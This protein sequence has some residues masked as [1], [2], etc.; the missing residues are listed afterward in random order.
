MIFC[1]RI[2]ETNGKILRSTKSNHHKM[3]VFMKRLVLAVF[4]F[5]T[6]VGTAMLIS[7][8]T[9][10]SSQTAAAEAWGSRPGV[11]YTLVM[12]DDTYTVHAMTARDTFGRDSASIS[13]FAAAFPNRGDDLIIFN[14][15]FFVTATWDPVGALV[16]QGRVV[17]S[18]PNP[19]LNWG[20]GFTDYNRFGLFYGRLSGNQVLDNLTREP[21]PYVTVF[22][23]YPHLVVNGVRPVLAPF[24]G[25]DANELNRRITRGFV[26]QRADGSFMIGRANNTNL[27]ELQNIAVDFGL[28]NAANIDGGASVGIW[29][30]GSYIVRPGRQLPAVIVITN[31][32][33]EGLH[34][35]PEDLEPAATHMIF[36]AD[37]TNAVFE[38]EF[39]NGVNYATTEVLAEL[40]FAFDFSD[41]VWG[42]SL[43]VNISRGG[44][45]LVVTMGS[46][47]FMVNGEL[48]DHN[49]APFFDRVRWS[50]MIPISCF[51]ESLG[52]T[53]EWDEYD[54]ALI[55]H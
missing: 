41:W 4:C 39:F 31:N 50:I 20:A 22:N 7:Y 29:R 38:L 33:L 44:Q 24:P 40:G 53:L 49:A 36:S 45:A 32:R 30:N 51:L 25:I 13:E 26:G 47:S 18:D 16:S 17:S 46:D 3:E 52:Y 48:F 42:Q 9:V 23:P 14:A 37:E 54:M 28:V 11:T 1:L 27:F 34:I 12:L 35:E 5:L 19:W 43:T 8:E 2:F 55:V 6:F 10:F 15:Q 21:L